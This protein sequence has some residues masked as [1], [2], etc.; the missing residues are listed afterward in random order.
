MLGQW[1]GAAW[2]Q[3][4]LKWPKQI[5]LQRVKTV[6]KIEIFVNRNQNFE[7]IALFNNF[8]SIKP[9]FSHNQPNFFLI[10]Q[11]EQCD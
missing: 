11:V 2:K 5:P 6:N 10:A 1:G 9:F 8:Y 4:S 7:R 3:H